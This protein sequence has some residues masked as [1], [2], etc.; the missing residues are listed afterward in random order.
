M[1]RILLLSDTHSHIDDRIMN[2]VEAADEVWHAGDI[3]DLSV[4][5]RI[6]KKVTLRAVYGNIDNHKARAEYPLVNC[7]VVEGLKVF[8][9]HIGGYPGRYAPGVKD[10]LAKEKPGLFIS[11]HSHILKVK[12]DKDLN[13]LHMNP[14]AAG[15]HG[16][17]SMRTMLRFEVYKGKVENLEVIELGKRGSIK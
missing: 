7:F 10:Q 4:T 16:F 13:L 11:G 9:T 3:G 2:F 12:F 14:G 17:H 1:K 6:A 15:I 5:D 8:I